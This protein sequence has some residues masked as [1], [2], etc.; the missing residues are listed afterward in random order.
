MATK[1]NQVNLMMLN[2]TQDMKE[3]YLTGVNDRLSFKKFLNLP[4]DTPSPL[5]GVAPYR[6]E[7][8][9]STFSRFRSRLSK[10]A[11]REGPLARR[12]AMIKLKH[13]ILL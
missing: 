12:E 2:A 10:A 13:A 8:D 3:N 6:P 7:A 9:H 11:G 4:L 5:R 1:N